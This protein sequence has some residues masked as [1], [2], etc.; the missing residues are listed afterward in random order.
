MTNN[1]EYIYSFPNTSCTLRAIV[2]LRNKHQ[3]YLESV[4]VINLIDRWLVR[5]NVKNSIPHRSTKN[6]HAFLSEM[7]SVSQPPEK[8]RKVLTCLDCGETPT[9]I[10]N[11]DRVVI[12][13]YGKPETEEIEI[14]RDRVIDGLGYCPQ[15]MI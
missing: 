10:M 7:G 11:R 4:A 14:F 12:V 5:L 2:Y 6:L 13:A 3:A 1:Q 8:I 15:N 9:E